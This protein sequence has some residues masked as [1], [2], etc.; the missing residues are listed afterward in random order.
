VA[1]GFDV[2]ATVLDPIG[3]LFA[4]GIGWIID[5]LEPI[6][7][8]FD[9][10]TGNPEAVAAFAGT[11]HNISTRLGEIEDEYRREA[12]RMLSGMTGPAI[13]AYRRHV[14]NQTSRLGTL[15]NVTGGVS[16]G[17]EAMSVLVT[18]VHGIVRDALASVIGSIISYVAEL[19]FTLGLATPLV[20]AQATSRVSALVAEIL[21]KIRGLTAS[22]RS[23]DDILSSLKDILNDIP[24]FL[25]DRYSVPN[26]PGV[27]WSNVLDE[28]GSWIRHIPGY[29]G[30][31]VRDQLAIIALRDRYKF[32]IENNPGLWDQAVRQA[33]VAAAPNNINDTVKKIIDAVERQTGAG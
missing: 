26:L 32:F 10:L 21:P 3:S 12:D 28:S 22:G 20:I 14:E 5:H 31:T 4:A 17:L 25:G 15:E 18:F 13:E 33:V 1:V 8:W 2:Y 16:V 19:V 9:D 30:A 23:L 27:R 7:G 29:T 11:W 24:R 6:K